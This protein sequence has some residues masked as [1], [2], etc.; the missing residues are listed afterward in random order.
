VYAPHI[1]IFPALLPPYAQTPSSTHYINS[2]LILG[3]ITVSSLQTAFFMFG[4][5]TEA[6]VGV[7]FVWMHVPDRSSSFTFSMEM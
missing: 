1:T 7:L 3:K 6:E 5:V 2:P 4:M